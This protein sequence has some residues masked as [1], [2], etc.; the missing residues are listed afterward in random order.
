MPKLYK[1]VIVPT[2]ASK[3]ITKPGLIS[4][5]AE[6]KKILACIPD[7]SLTT[8][9]FVAYRELEKVCEYYIDNLV[10]EE[11]KEIEIDLDLVVGQTFYVGYRN[12]AAV[13]GD[14]MVVIIYEK[15]A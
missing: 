4:T 1:T 9:Y 3:E 5:V 7:D 14:K 13:S 11:S 12:P 2:E 6:P 8:S 15:T 10:G